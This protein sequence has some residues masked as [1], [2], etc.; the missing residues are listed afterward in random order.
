MV[1]CRPLF[2]PHLCGVVLRAGQLFSAEK[3]VLL[4]PSVLLPRKPL[5]PLW[6][7]N[8]KSGRVFIQKVEHNEQLD[9][10]ESLW[11]LLPRQRAAS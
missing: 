4:P 1:G 11:A 10:F 9:R 2:G 5:K 7:N 3:M 8:W 6:S